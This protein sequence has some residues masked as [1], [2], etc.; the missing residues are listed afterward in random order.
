[1]GDVVLWISVSLD[2]YMAGPDGELDW[3]KV[4][5][6]LHQYANDEIRKVGMFLNGRVNYEMM[7]EFWP[8]LDSDPNITGPMKEFAGIWRDMPKVVYSRTL[9]HADWNSTIV[10]D[11]IPEEV[12]ELKAH[13]TA[14]LLVEGPTWLPSSS[15]SI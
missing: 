6:E 10:R 1:M 12:M 13:S 4:D 14:D 5:E 11:V 2:G 3:H 15:V 7:A 9:E 8:T